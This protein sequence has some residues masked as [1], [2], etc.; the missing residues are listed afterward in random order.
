[1]FHVLSFQLA[2][3]AFHK[4]VKDDPAV[5]VGVSEGPFHGF[6]NDCEAVVGPKFEES[7]SYF[8]VAVKQVR[9]WWPLRAWEE[10]VPNLHPL[11]FNWLPSTR[12]LCHDFFPLLFRNAS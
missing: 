5:G 11:F 4:L 9:C 8:P 2:Q 12:V 3:E 10:G 6:G 7:G 1:V